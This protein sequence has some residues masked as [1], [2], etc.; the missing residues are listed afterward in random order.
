MVRHIDKVGMFVF[1]WRLPSTFNKNNMYLENLCN[2][3]YKT[4]CARFTAYRRMKRDRDASKVA[5]A[6]SSASIIAIS[7]ISLKVHNIE[8]SNNISILTIILSTFLLVVSLLFSNLDYEKRMDN[9]H[10]CGNDLSRLYR[11]MHHDSICLTEDK[12]K[13]KELE[14][15]NK[16]FD[17]LKKYNLNHTTFDYD[18][19]M[20]SI[21]YSKIKTYRWLW[22][23]IRYYFFDVYMLYW[24]I[25]LVPI[26]CIVPYYWQLFKVGIN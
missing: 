18:Y 9:Y 16:Y 2:I 13:E 12:Q 20:L 26:A 8:L 25:A 4:M 10:S 1:K 14:Y 23:K 19:A 22:L 17:I 5:E 15:L 21:T 24:L 3:V 6:F 11:F 7:L